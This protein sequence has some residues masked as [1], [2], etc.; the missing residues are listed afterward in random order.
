MWHDRRTFDDNLP[1]G[2]WHVTHR[3]RWVTD[4]ATRRKTKERIFDPERSR[5]LSWFKPVIEH[6]RDAAVLTWDFIEDDG[7]SSTYVWL[8]TDYLIVLAPRQLRSG[9]I[10]NLITAYAVDFP[11]KIRQLE[12][13]YARRK[14]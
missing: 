2:F 10:Y 3:D 8:K 5:R 13:R 14:R 4:A 9:T 12:D 6:D 11:D 1:E 7:R